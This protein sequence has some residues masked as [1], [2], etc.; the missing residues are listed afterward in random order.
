MTDTQEVAHTAPTPIYISKMAPAGVDGRVW[1]KVLKEQLLSSKGAEVTDEELLYFAQVCQ[2]TALDPTKREI[3]GIFRSVRQKDGTYKPKLSVQTGIDGF[4]VTAERSGKYGG[5]KEPEFI[6]DGELKISV[7]NG[8]STKIVPN[9]AKVTVL[10]VMGDRVLETTRAAQ[11]ADYYPGEKE[12]MMWRKLPEV[13]LAKVAE[14]QALRAAF[15][16]CAQL[17]LEEEISTPIEASEVGKVDMNKIVE[18]VKAAKDLDELLS[19]IST[20]S[21]EQQKQVTQVAAERAA[22]LADKEEVKDASG[23]A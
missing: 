12:G 2:S 7:N 1:A 22:E 23:A 13:M 20:L 17:Y 11:W 8:G 10:K 16:N 21:V 19:I 18:Q 15:P 9:T 6:Y 5:S 4:R 3:Y 14:A